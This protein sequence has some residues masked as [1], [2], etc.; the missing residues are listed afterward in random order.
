MS[1]DWFT[2]N[3]T[4]VPLAIMREK[5]LKGLLRKKKVD[6][7]ESKN[8]EWKDLSDGYIPEQLLNA[9]N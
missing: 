7:I 5:Q 2:S 9:A 6:L 8:P 1:L 3:N 4:A